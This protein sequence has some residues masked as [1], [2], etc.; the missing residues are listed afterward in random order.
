MMNSPAQI[1][2][3]T[4]ENPVIMTNEKDTFK[5]ECEYKSGMTNWNKNFARCPKGLLDL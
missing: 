3:N 2:N 1:S 4:A 5:K